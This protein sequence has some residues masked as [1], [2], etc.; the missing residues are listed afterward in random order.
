[1]AC[2]RGKIEIVNALDDSAQCRAIVDFERCAAEE[3]LAG[4]AQAWQLM[5]T[6]DRAADRV[7]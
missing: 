2:V 5:Q 1:M 4:F 3:Q 7:E 6:F